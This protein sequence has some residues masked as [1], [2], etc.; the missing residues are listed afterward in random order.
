LHVQK[1]G[2]YYRK[3][4][5]KTCSVTAHSTVRDQISIRNK[6]YSR[7]PDKRQEIE[8]LFLRKTVEQPRG[9]RSCYTTRLIGFVPLSLP[10]VSPLWLLQITVAVQ[11]TPME[12]TLFQIRRRNEQKEGIPGDIWHTPHESRGSLRRRNFGP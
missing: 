1:I 9:D 10:S 2:I 8:K 4:C 3:S 12:Q 11:A 7:I 6:V 5:K